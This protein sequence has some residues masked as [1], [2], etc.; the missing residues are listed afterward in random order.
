M[1]LC[2][3]LGHTWSLQIIHVETM[4]GSVVLLSPKQRHHGHHAMDNWS[5]V[6]AVGSE[7]FVLRS[8]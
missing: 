7:V 1:I 3:A 6:I 2:I 4:R 5:K 8:K